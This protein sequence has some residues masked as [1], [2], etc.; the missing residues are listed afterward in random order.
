MYR[1]L[2]FFVLFAV[3]FCGCQPSSRDASTASGIPTVVVSIEPQ[4]FF[5]QKIAGARIAVEVL[6]PTGKEPETYVPSPDKIKKLTQSRLFFQIGFPSEETFLP[7]LKTLA[8]NLKIVDTRE[9]I[10]LRQ[11]E[12]HDHE[13]EHGHDHHHHADGMDPHIWLSPSLVLRQTDSILQALIEL[14]PE[15][16]AEFEENA[17][18]FRQELEETRTTIADILAPHQG[19][20][21][22][23][24]HPAYGYFCDEFGLKQKAIEV[25]GKSPKIKELAEWKR[26]AL[27]DN[28]HLILVQ[29]EFNPAPAEKIAA[30]IGAKAI[31]HS[32]LGPNYLDDLVELAKLISDSHERN[33][34]P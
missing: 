13:H 3:A 33:E 9:G 24:F 18:I 27:E 15:G 21:I 4:Q 23:V 1:F 20:T 16:K 25:E 30:E 7:K 26:Q 17:K 14:D 29:P 11:M 5:V 12:A 2:S 34:T 32:T 6:V 31:V 8:P 28:V 22:Y 19:E 10:T